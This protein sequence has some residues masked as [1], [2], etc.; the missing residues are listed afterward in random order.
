MQPKHFSNPF[1]KKR[2]IVCPWAEAANI[3]APE[4]Q[5]GLAF[6]HPFCQIFSGAAGARDTHRIEARGDEQAFQFRRSTEN[7]VI[8]RREAFGPVHELC[9]LARL[10]RRDA[11]LSV[12]EWYREFLPVRRKE[13]FAV[14]LKDGKH[15]IPALET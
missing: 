9:E 15:R 8:V 12:L 14:P 1:A 3:D 2:A 4:I 7:E 5:R 6:D 10:K 11:M 13:K